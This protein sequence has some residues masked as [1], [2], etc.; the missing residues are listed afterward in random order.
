MKKIFYFSFYLVLL[1]SC[2]APYQV[3]EASSTEVIQYQ[4]DAFAYENE[5]LAIAYDFWS[6][7]GFILFNI[8]NKT[9]STL[10]INLS[11]STFT[12]NGESTSYYE[13]LPPAFSKQIDESK[14]IKPIPPQESFTIE[15]FSI[16]ERWLRDID[17]EEQK[18]FD[19]NKS[20]FLFSNYIVYAFEPKSETILDVNNEFWV[21]SVARMKTAD[22][23]DYGKY[24]E[25]TTN[26]FYIAKGLVEEDN[27]TAFWF[28]VAVNILQVL[29]LF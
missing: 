13:K 7:G 22:F 1:S 17:K 21:S 25:D 5:D 18:T 29:L 10:Y 23:K 11:K 9:D 4:D 2:T 27:Q 26:K 3:F 12:M 19:K 28:D 16:N 14:F 6:N 24:G 20:P 15:G 8:H